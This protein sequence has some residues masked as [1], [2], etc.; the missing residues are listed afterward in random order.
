VEKVHINFFVFIQKLCA[1]VGVSMHLIE[2]KVSRIVSE[3]KKLFDVDVILLRSRET[4]AYLFSELYNPPPEDVP[5]S[6]VLIDVKSSYATAYISLLDYHRANE[7]YSGTHLIDFVPV[8][9]H[10]LTLQ[11]GVKVLTSDEVK[12]EI[13][14]TISSAKA[15]ATDF[16]A[17]CEQRLCSNIKPIIEVLRRRKIDAELELIR[18]AIDITERV[19][20][21]SL[22]FISPGI[23]E[24]ALSG[25]LIEM[26]MALGA[27]GIAFS[28]I[29]AIGKNAAKPHHIVQSTVF[30]GCEP[31]LIDF[32][33]RVRGYVSDVTRMILPRRLCSEYVDVEGNALLISEVIDSAIVNLKPNTAA[34]GIDSVAR[35]KLK[36]RGLDAYF[37]HGLGHGIGVDVHE[38][39]RISS[40]S[41]DTLLPG[42]TIT[43]EPGVYFFNK[44][45]VRI[46]EDV[47]VD[48]NGGKLLTTSPRTLY[49]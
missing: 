13:E 23:S 19:L 22:T 24:K 48:E 33:V 49:L 21:N 12:R 1:K 14:S 20:V 5:V 25:K 29:V 34:S 46:E 43:V 16:A 44:Y 35:E 7:T 37:I 36:E 8:F 11:S 40:N 2:L 6:N 30:N 31:I 42:D 28:P 9:S 10:S 32:G 26:A 45:G 4:L 27:E 39:P 38:P 17:F 15:F 18:R 41:R 47:Y 3:V